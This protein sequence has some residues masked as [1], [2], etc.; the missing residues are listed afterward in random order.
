MSRIGKQIVKIP[1]DI[2]VTQEGGFLFF[3]KGNKSI[4]VASVS[5]V[6]PILSAE[7]LKFELL[8]DSKQSRSNWGTIASLCLNAVNGL[9]KDFEK[10]LL[11]EGIGYKVMQ[12]GNKLVFTLGFSHPVNFEVPAEVEV[13]VEKNKI[14][15]LKSFDKA[16]LGQTAA[17]IRA[18]KKPE[19][20]KGKGIRYEGEVIKLK[21]GKKSVSS[22]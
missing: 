2:A 4:K 18:F 17:K 21:A 8:N 10:N 12:E 7:E 19:P 16:I 1:Q 15:K 14:I 13:T 9:S 11:I 20:Y 5:G 6:K 22:S 3:K